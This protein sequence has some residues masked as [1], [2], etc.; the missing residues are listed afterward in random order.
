MSHAASS[1]SYYDHIQSIRDH[2]QPQ[3]ATNGIHLNIAEQLPAAANGKLIC[4]AWLSRVLVFLASSVAPLATAGY[5]SWHPTCAATDGD[6]P[7]NIDA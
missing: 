5:Q 1:R 7:H 3:G 2:Q 6:R 4:A